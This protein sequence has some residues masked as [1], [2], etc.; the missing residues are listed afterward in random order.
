MKKL[1]TAF[2]CLALFGCASSKP[3]VT[4]PP[5]NQADVVA[6]QQPAPPPVTPP[7]DQ[8][9]DTYQVDL[10][11]VSFKIP[12]PMTLDKEDSGDGVM[13]YTLADHSLVFGFSSQET[14]MELDQFAQVTVIAAKLKDIEVMQVR[15]GQIDNQR[16]LMLIMKES[17]KDIIDLH[18]IVKNKKLMMN[19]DCGMP[20]HALL[21]KNS[22]MCKQI[23]ESIKL[24]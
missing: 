14:D 12:T 3:A 8:P 22:G 24:K 13:I 23:I 15:Q 17:E 5:H 16:A 19:F 10:E 6:N 18:F 20:A 11:S 21:K 4:T 7:S 2:I 9:T 1:L